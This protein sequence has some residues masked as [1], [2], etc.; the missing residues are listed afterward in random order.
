MCNSLWRSIKIEKE[1]DFVETG[2]EF[3]EE[4]FVIKKGKQLQA[5]LDKEATDKLKD[6]ILFYQLVEFSPPYS[7]IV[8]GLC[9]TMYFILIMRH[10]QK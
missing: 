1:Y 10:I 9:T 4:K 6:P 2:E 7:F 8:V 3:K 5:S